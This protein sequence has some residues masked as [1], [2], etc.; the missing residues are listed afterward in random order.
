MHCI[1]DCEPQINVSSGY[2]KDPVFDAHLARAYAEHVRIMERYDKEMRE[3][4]LLLEVA[5]Q[6]SCEAM[7]SHWAPTRCMDRQT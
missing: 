4:A 3:R 1:A 5:Q 2:W 6:T 7:T